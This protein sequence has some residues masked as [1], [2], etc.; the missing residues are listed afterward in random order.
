MSLIWTNPFFLPFLLLVAGPLLIHLLARQRPPE[1]PF[2]T[3]TFIHKLQRQT[4]RL[5]QPRHWLL[6]LL[7]TLFVLLVLLVF[8]QPVLFGRWPG[9]GR[10]QRQ[11]VV[12]VVDASAS[13]GWAEGAQT[14]FAAAC[15]EASTVL[16]GLHTG[17]QAAVVW[18]AATPRA[19]LPVLG[20]N[21]AF[22]QE[23][24]RRGTVTAQSANLDEA[25]QLALR[26]LE[27]AEGRGEICVFSDGQATNWRGLRFQPPPGVGF[28]EVNVAKGEAANVGITR[29]LFAPAR[30]LPGE[31][32]SILCEVSNFSASPQRRTVSMGV[33]EQRSSQEA[34]LPAWGTVNVSFRQR[35]SVPGTVVV[36][37]ALSEDAFPV[38]DRR[39]AVLEVRAALRAGLLSTD[40]DTAA[41]WRRALNAVGWAQVE[42]LTAADLATANP[43]RDAL[44]LAGWDGQNG[45]G[46]RA[47]L[48]AGT[49]VLWAPGPGVTPAQLAAYFPGEGRAAGAAAAGAVPWEE[50]PHGFRLKV[51]A[52]EHP[53]FAVF[54]NGEQ[55]DPVTGTF[56][57]RL[58]LPVGLFPGAATLLAYE[59]NVP[60]LCELRQR[61]T[62]LLWNLPLGQPR[63]SW[64]AQPGFLPL[65]GELLLTARAPGGSGAGTLATFTGQSLSLRLERP[66]APADVALLSDIDGKL[67]FHSQAEPSGSCFVSEPVPEP[68]HYRWLCQEATVAE[69]AVNVPES[70]SD[71]RRLPAAEVK[72]TGAAVAASGTAWRQWQDG[73]TLWPLLLGL[74]CVLIVL[75]GAA[76]VWSES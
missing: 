74:A 43:G 39:W 22:L 57:A 1:Y 29:L 23:Q 47:A 69:A 21:I 62:L 68:G 33:Q 36:A 45:P 14:R 46:V 49:T 38:D 28:S 56:F 25:L 11:Q 50:N 58:R 44:L 27:G 37:A 59:D 12:L 55:G 17:D 35:F 10:F 40:A 60:A 66:V 24:L 67:G 20:G 65:F 2:S 72:Q 4:L 32:V 63:S 70:E 13:M 6:L 31:E 54:A 41:V 76:Q 73:V 52:P 71:L 9:A 18:A 53:A 8:L 51:A 48:A 26:L 34:V 42:E 3:V 61:G 19:A 15:A 30:P 5:K 75:E 64:A 16:A 7:R